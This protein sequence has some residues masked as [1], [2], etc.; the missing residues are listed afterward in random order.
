[1]PQTT[2]RR[3]TNVGTAPERTPPMKSYYQAHKAEIAAYQKAYRQAN[4]AKILADRK[5]YYE[6]HKAESAAYYQTHK[7]E[8]LVYA[9][10]YNR[11]HKSQMLAYGK[12]YRQT[13]KAEIALNGKASRRRKAELISALIRYYETSEHMRALRLLQRVML[14]PRKDPQKWAGADARILADSKAL[15]LIAKRISEIMDG[16]SRGKDSRHGH[17]HHSEPA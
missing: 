4:K 14:R 8:R 11:A 15:S 7:A 12:T 2:T 5:A 17:T 6:A 16:R 13:H 9:K 3:T 1:M 10:A